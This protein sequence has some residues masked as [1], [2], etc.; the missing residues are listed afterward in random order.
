MSSFYGSVGVAFNKEYVSTFYLPVFEL[1]DDILTIKNKFE[2][3]PSHLTNQGGN[4]D[5]ETDD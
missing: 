1:E 5:I 2:Q 3:K 4:L